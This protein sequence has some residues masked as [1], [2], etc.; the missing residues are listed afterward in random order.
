MSK[1]TLLTIIF[2]M[3]L[4]IALSFF[5]SKTF[6]EGQINNDAWLLN[7]GDDFNV[8]SFKIDYEDVL[9]QIG[10]GEFKN[11][12]VEILLSKDWIINKTSPK[13]SDLIKNNGEV[14]FNAYSIEENG[15]IPWIFSITKNDFF[16][17]PDYIEKLQENGGIIIDKQEDGSFVAEYDNGSNKK[18]TIMQKIVKTNDQK[19]IIISLV[20]VNASLEKVKENFNKLLEDCTVLNYLETIQLFTFNDEDI[21]VVETMEVVE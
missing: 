4:I 2:G 16:E 15:S 14:F 20:T 1:K 17:I 6:R 10:G 7:Q 11:E 13:N 8:D 3:L 12:D 21:D 18:T 9:D 19:F 5:S